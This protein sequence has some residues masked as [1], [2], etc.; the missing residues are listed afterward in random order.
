MPLG[1]GPAGAEIARRG[2]EG[3]VLHAADRLLVVRLGAPHA[4]LS[5]ALVNGG[6]RTAAE[7]AW[8]EVRDDELRPPADASALLRARLAAAGIPEA[9]GLLT[10]CALAAH[11]VAERSA[12][13]LSARCVAT[14]GLGNALRVGD[15]PGPA[16]RVGTINLL[17]QVSAPLSEAALAEALS[18]AVEARTL[19]VL[20]AGVPSGRTGLASTGTGTDCVALAAPERGAGVVRYAGKHTAA[21][22]VIGAAVHEAV[23]RGVAAWLVEHAPER[24]G[25]RPGAASLP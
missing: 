3:I 7:V 16:A 11:V 25:P 17:C 21:G 15:P 24:A 20:E 14:V 18:I 4:V 12:D 22:H 6:R 5:W 13:G 1:G 8:A 23:A 9:V 2:S 19:A 10:S